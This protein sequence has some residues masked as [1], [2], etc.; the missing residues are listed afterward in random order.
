MLFVKYTTDRN[1]FE[2]DSYFLIRRFVSKAGIFWKKNI[3]S[4]K[5]MSA[6]EKIDNK[7]LDDL[8]LEIKQALQIKLTDPNGPTYQSYYN[9][10]Y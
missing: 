4:D 8:L 7:E 5:N 2:S 9:L 1:K 10:Y 6:N 3:V